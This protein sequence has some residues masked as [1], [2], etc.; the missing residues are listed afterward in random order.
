MAGF[1]K[2]V[3]ETPSTEPESAPPPS[4]AATGDGAVN[5]HM[6]CTVRQSGIFAGWLDYSGPGNHLWLSGDDPDKP[7][8]MKLTWYTSGGLYLNPQGTYVGDPRYLGNNGNDDKWT[9]TADWNYWARRTAVRWEKPNG[10]IFY[11]KNPNIF[12]VNQGGGWVNWSSDLT[13]Q[14]ICEPV[15]V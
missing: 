14:M 10:P 15:F 5:F 12:L 1:K 9:G 6:K 13:L 7:T 11:S 4:T 2:P 8:G 3:N